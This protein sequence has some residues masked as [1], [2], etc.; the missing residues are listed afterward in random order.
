MVKITFYDEEKYLL[1]TSSILMLPSIYG[2]MTGNTTSAV[3]NTLSCVISS[4]FWYYP[5]LGMRRNI[6]LLYQPL[7]AGYMLFLGN[8]SESNIMYKMIG[9]GFFLSGTLLYNK[10][11]ERYKNGDR[12]WYIY[13]GLFHIS[14]TTAALCS[15]YSMNQYKNNIQL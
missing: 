3:L 6:D 14:M 5:I 15:Y 11:C 9:N 10:S 2:Y 7:F 12:F 13:H 4:T 8:T 1:T